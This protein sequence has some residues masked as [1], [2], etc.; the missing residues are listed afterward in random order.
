MKQHTTTFGVFKPVDHVL[1]S[2]PTTADADAAAQALIDAGFKSADIVRYSPD[3][4]REQAESDIQNASPL[5]SLGQ[6]L[7]LVKEQLELALQGQSFLLVHA[8]EDAQVERVTEV[9]RRCHATR[10]QRYGT[11]VVEELLPVG[12]LN[13]QVAESPDRGLDAQTASGV[14][15]SR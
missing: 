5:A 9:A 12:D 6:D 15:G 8:S 3:E 13:Q 10:A 14:E 1:L 11:L 7:N 2:L 4:M